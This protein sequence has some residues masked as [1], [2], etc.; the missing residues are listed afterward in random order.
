[1]LPRVLEPEVMDTAEEAEDYD[2]MDHGTV[3]QTFVAD[4]LA[5][6][7]THGVALDASM[8]ILDAG[9]GTALIP[10]VLVQAGCAAHI[11]AADAAEEM[12]KL[13][14]VNI[15]RAGL[16]SQITPVLRDCKA[17]PEADGTLAAV[18]SNSIIHH[19]PEPSAVFAECWRILQPGGLLFVRDLAR[20]ESADDVEHLVRT[21][22]GAESLRQQQL[23]R[24][25]LHAALT[26]E[27]IAEM[28]Q[29]LGIA[30]TA[31]TMTSDRHWTVSARKP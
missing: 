3:N 11:V 27:E 20:P 14:A 26:A 6:V 1:M 21:Y 2:R 5:A 23:F 19:I 18:M 8:Q 29:P 10:I 16:S 9:T 30:T 24:Q 22:A 7:A 31:V 25:S 17:L 28:L 13:A 15:A 4:F 12:L